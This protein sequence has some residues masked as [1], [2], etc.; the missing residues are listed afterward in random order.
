MEIYAWLVLRIAYAWIFLVPLPSLLKNWHETKALTALLFPQKTTTTLT[1]VMLVAMFF[2]A[3]SILFGILGQWAGLI[4]MVY[5]LLGVIVHRRLA[6]NAQNI[7]LS[8]SS[9]A[10]DQQQLNDLIGL[11]VAGN[12]GSAYKNIVLAAIGFF[13]MVMGTGPCSVL[14]QNFSSVIKTWLSA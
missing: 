12:I 11:A 13:F 9:S 8:T 1:I 10:A 5:C 14:H 2:G 3:L 7:R 4:L 6:K